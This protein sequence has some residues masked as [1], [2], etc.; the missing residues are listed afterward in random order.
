MSTKDE[1]PKE[2]GKFDFSAYPPDTLFYDR[3]S[4]HERRD[5][6]PTLPPEPTNVAPRERRARKERRRRVD[7]T[8][9]EKQYTDDEIEFMNSI[10]Q[11]KSRTGKSFPSYGDVLRVAAS[12][13][14]RK[15]YWDDI[16]PEETPSEESSREVEPALPR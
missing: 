5:S 1:T 14:Y 7:P 9:F 8:T 6:P 3:R 2:A 10:Q 4:G 11:F 15:A 16:D 12:L 13:G